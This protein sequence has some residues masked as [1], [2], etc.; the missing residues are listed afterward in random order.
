MLLQKMLS[1]T[2]YSISYLNEKLLEDPTEENA[3]KLF[4]YIE[5]CKQD[6]INEDSMHKLYA[7]TK[8]WLW[9]LDFHGWEPAK[10]WYW[11]I[12]MEDL[13]FFTPGCFQGVNEQFWNCDPETLELTRIE[14]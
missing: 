5:E 14:C 4:S 9:N 11:N 2:F 1:I 13:D 6:M 12:F 3:I 8:A 10:T 7:L